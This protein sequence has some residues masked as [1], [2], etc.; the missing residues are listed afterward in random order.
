MRTNYLR[1]W[2]VLVL[3]VGVYAGCTSKPDSKIP[4]EKEMHFPSSI[5]LSK[6]GRTVFVASH[7][8]DGRYDLGR[9]VTLNASAI[10]QVIDGTGEKKPLPWMSVIET[11]NLIPADI[12]QI[13]LTDNFA[14]FASRQNNHL[15][16]LPVSLGKPSCNKPFEEASS[17]PQATSYALSEVDPFA[18]AGL[19]SQGLQDTAVVSYL[20]SDRIDVFSIEPGSIKTI[21]SLWAQSWLSAK[22]S[23]KDLAKRRVITKKIVVSFKNDASRSKTYFLLE[24]H[25]QKTTGIAKAKAL[26]VIAISTEALLAQESIT[27]S[28]IEIWDLQAQFAIASANDFYVDEINNHAYLLARAPEALFKIDL[29]KKELLDTAIVCQGATSFTLDATEN[30]MVVPCFSDN[31]LASYSLKPLRHLTTSPFIGRGPTA[32]VIDAIHRLVYCTFSLEGVARVFDYT[33]GDLGYVFQK[34]P[35]YRVGS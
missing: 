18:L 4:D 28:M 5:A 27:E 20:S 34:A 31:R 29:G 15:V 12:S 33:F 35:P 22:L 1:F 19:K 23:K 14:L 24:T 32:C 26:Y 16:A 10:K 30:M 21:K 7:D 11:N 25:P 9:L 17:C 6:D 13:H 3:F 2:P 8:S